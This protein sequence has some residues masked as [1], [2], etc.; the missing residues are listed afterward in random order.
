MGERICHMRTNSQVPR[1]IT[2]KNT[3]D[4]YY[5]IYYVGRCLITDVYEV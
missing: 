2:Y 4:T 3:N 1:H 5:I